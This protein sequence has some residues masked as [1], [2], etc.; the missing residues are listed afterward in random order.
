MRAECE[1]G[2]PGGGGG[3]RAYASAG[4]HPPISD[5]AP[6]AAGRGVS[7]LTRILVA[8]LGGGARDE[9]HGEAAMADGAEGLRGGAV[10][11]V[12]AVEPEKIGGGEIGG[13]RG[14]RVVDEAALAGA[15]HEE[16]EFVCGEKV[17]DGGDR[18]G[19]ESGAALSEEAVARGGVDNHGG[20]SR[21]VALSGSA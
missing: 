19:L 2:G 7:W 14:E 17:G 4:T 8:G 11:A 5:M 1:F 15:G 3:R 21:G 10:R 20:D 6:R 9:L 12:R 16:G 13:E 18:D